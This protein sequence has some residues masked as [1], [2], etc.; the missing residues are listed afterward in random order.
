MAIDIFNIEP[1]KVSRSL[2]GYTIMFYGEPK[3]GATN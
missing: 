1:H 3:T 2:E